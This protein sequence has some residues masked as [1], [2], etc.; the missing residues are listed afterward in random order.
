MLGAILFNYLMQGKPFIAGGGVSWEKEAVFAA[1]ALCLFLAGPGI[2]SIDDV[3][4]STRL[5]TSTA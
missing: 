1:A 3:M 2:W 5:R 4:I